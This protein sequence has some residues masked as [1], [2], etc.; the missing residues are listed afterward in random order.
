MRRQWLWGSLLALPLLFVFSALHLVSR[1]TYAQTVTTP[2]QI[3]NSEEFMFDVRVDLDLLADA[4]FTEGVRPEAWIGNFELGSATF[5]IDTWFD[6]ELLADEVLG[7]GIRPDDWQGADVPIATTIA[8][9]V[10]YDIEYLADEA[11]GIGVRPEGWRGAPPIL[12]CERTIQNVVEMLSRFYRI[13]PQT[14]QSAINY[15]AAIQAELEDEMVN[16]VF[17]TPQRNQPAFDPLDGL[18]AVRGDLE[19]T[20][21]ELL[22]LNTRPVGYVGNR[23]RGSM[24]LIGDLF[25]DINLLADDQL[26]QGVRPDGWIGVVSTVPAVSYLNLRHDVELLTDVTL[27]Y[28]VRPNGWQGVNTLERCM[29]LVRTLAYLDEQNY[30]VSFIELDPAAPDYCEQLTDAVNAVVE[31]PPVLDVAEVDNRYTGASNYAFTYLDIGAHQY[32]GIM[33]G[34]TQFRAVYRNYGESNMM[35][36]SGTDFALY[37]D[38]RFTNVEETVF[39][40]L[41]TVENVSPIT[42]CDA[43]WCNGPGPTPTPTGSGPLLEIILQTTPVSPPSQAELEITKQMVTWNYVRVTYVQDNLAARTAQVTIELC[44][45]PVE[46]ATTC[47]PVTAV[48]DTSSGTAKPVLSVFNGLNVYEFSYGYITN[49]VMESNTRFANDVWIS[50]PTI[51]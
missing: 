11:L 6:A 38:R 13:N 2:S 29:P 34:G 46:A 15:C 16:I 3:A 12:R 35:F 27:G 4:V 17:G 1:P 5:V 51:R 45:V 21:D 19:R 23:D 31:N 44:S 28:N 43:Y 7:I 26:G 47:E 18:A 25:I 41:P 20:A 24:T 30:G 14:P 40:S 50:D 48:F 36:V 39:N 8:R 22:G 37:V 33:P 10:R 49:V 32:M 9:N 42:Y